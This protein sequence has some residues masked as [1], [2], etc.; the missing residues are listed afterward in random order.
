M[1]AYSVDPIFGTIPISGPL[2]KR[3]A[4]ELLEAHIALR[5]IGSPFAYLGRIEVR[6]SI[7]RVVDYLPAV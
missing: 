1:R 7:G 2:T 6:D 4:D 3:Q 5:D